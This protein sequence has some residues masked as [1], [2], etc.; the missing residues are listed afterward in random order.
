ME[1]G[2][3]EQFQS[4]ERVDEKK[5]EIAAGAK[6]QLLG[7]ERKEDLKLLTANYEEALKRLQ[8]EFENYKKKKEKEKEEYRK[9][10][11]AL[12]LREFLPFLDEFEIAVL[13]VE[14]K[15]PELG[16]G[17]MLLY[18]KFL[19]LLKKEGLSGMQV[20]KGDWFDPYLHEALE[21]AESEL[22]E[23]KIIR[24][25]RKGYLFKGDVIRHA[26]VCVSKD[27]KLDEKR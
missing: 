12:L 19:S 15:S 14:K 2:K 22:E 8:A 11:N 18:S 13:E 17:L 10:A 3:Q 9:N 20:K 21:R 7:T 4:S 1:K 26:G 23:G 27:K 24:V 16:K 25:M 5:E 6:E